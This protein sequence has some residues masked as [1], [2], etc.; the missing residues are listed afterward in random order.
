VKKTQYHIQ[1]S[2]RSKTSHLTLKWKLLRVL[3]F[4]MI[5]ISNILFTCKTNDNKLTE[6]FPY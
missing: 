1:S 3:R 2:Q 4:K 5:A 6:L